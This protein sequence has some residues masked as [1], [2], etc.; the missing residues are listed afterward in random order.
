MLNYFYLMIGW[1][2][3]LKQWLRPIFLCCS[4][5]T[6]VGINFCHTFSYVLYIIWKFWIIFIFPVQFDF[7]WRVSQAVAVS[8]CEHQRREGVPLLPHVRH[9]RFRRDRRRRVQGGLVYLRSHQRKPGGVPAG[10]LRHSHGWGRMYICM[11][12]YVFYLYLC[13]ICDINLQ[14]IDSYLYLLVSIWV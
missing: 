1:W 13:R 6:I 7:F 2:K 12:V 14:C 3:W 8:E 4:M 5:K 10:E 11:Y 9:G